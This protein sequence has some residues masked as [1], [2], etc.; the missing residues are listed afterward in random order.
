MLPLAKQ[1]RHASLKQ[2]CNGVAY[3]SKPE[4]LAPRADTG[5][6]LRTVRKDV[7]QLAGMR[8]MASVHGSAFELG[9][10]T[11]LDSQAAFEAK[12]EERSE[13]HPRVMCLDIGRS[14]IGVAFSHTGSQWKFAFPYKVI[15][16]YSE[17][18]GQ[19]VRA[20]RARI[21]NGKIVEKMEM[22]PLRVRSSLD[23]L[24]NQIEELVESHNV[25]M[26]VIGVPL[27]SKVE[28]FLTANQSLVI[29]NNELQTKDVGSGI[30][31]AGSKPPPSVESMLAFLRDFELPEKMRTTEVGISQ[32]ILRITRGLESRGVLRA[33]HYDTFLQRKRRLQRLESRLQ[34]REGRVPPTLADLV[35][36]LKADRASDEA[37]IDSLPSD[38]RTRKA[39][40]N[41]PSH[42]L[43]NEEWSTQRAQER[44]LAGDFADEISAKR[45]RL[46]KDELDA[47]AASE[48]LQ[49]AL[50]DVQQRF[51]IMASVA[52]KRAK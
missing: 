22:I 46:K 17:V 18:P 33:S 37:I 38:P 24:A 52:A 10:V 43:W 23:N 13:D 3:I 47:Y 15:S 25:L 41:L 4:V 19:M 35:Q 45:E 49:S 39:A 31:A 36:Q 8:K 5:Y 26:T 44:M 48:I 16:L 32:Y 7:Q 30:I 21:V 40:E 9:T 14:Y 28:A 42:V 12:E 34:S 50:D 51:D 1:L 27:S 2:L 11:D 20:P 29:Q 6:A